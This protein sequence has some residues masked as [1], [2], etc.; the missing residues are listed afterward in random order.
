MGSIW[1]SPTALVSSL[2]NDLHQHLPN[3][4][5]WR[6]SE[7]RNKRLLDLRCF[8]FHLFVSGQGLFPIFWHQKPE[9]SGCKV[10]VH[11]HH[12]C[13][14]SLNDTQRH[15][16]HLLEGLLLL[17][18]PLKLGRTQEIRQKSG[19]SV[20]IRNFYKPCLAFRLLQFDQSPRERLWDI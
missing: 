19:E 16:L 13:T 1:N 8:N 14:H 7:N 15:L 6:I 4:F 11:D 2:R 20:L 3:F 18:G 12:L 9:P 10:L 17:S 5:G